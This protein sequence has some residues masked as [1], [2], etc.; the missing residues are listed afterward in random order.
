MRIDIDLTK[1]VDNSYPIYLNQMERI[2]I[3]G[4]AAIVTNPKVAGLHLGSLL[5]KIDAKELYIITLPDGEQYKNQ[6]SLDMILEHLFNHIFSRRDTL[7]AFGGGVIGDMTGFAA[8]IFQRGIDFIQIP[9]TLLSQVDASVGGKT[10]INN[11]FGKNLVGAFYQPKAV[12]IENRFLR[13][14]PP[15]E[16]A[17]GVAEIAKMAIMFDAEFFAWLEEADLS[18]EESLTY[19][20]QRSIETKAEVVRLDEKERGVRAV[21]NYGHTFAH[22]IENLTGYRRYLHGEAVAIGMHMA[23]LLAQKLG[24]L[25]E[26]EV[27]RIKRFLEKSGL[28]TRFTIEDPEQFY[29]AFFLDKKA[30]DTRVTFILP[31][32][33]GA[34]E[35]RDDIPKS[36]VLEVLDAFRGS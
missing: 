13:T 28:P 9:T 21:L 1:Q 30:S 14:L 22:V 3:T 5:E 2:K 12:Y 34:Y 10:G 31:H 29:Q 36:T 17:A 11:R 27:E 25:S 19:A 15:R 33:I 8:A 4:K 7:I 18:E 6:Q 35:I 20:I 32:P 24:Y 16:F 23:N 26:E